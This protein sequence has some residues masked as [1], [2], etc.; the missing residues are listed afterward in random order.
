MKINR[1]TK[2]MARLG[3]RISGRP[4]NGYW[5]DVRRKKRKFKANLIWLFPAIASNNHNK[6]RGDMVPRWRT[7]N[8]QFY[9]EKRYKEISRDSMSQHYQSRTL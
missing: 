5:H 2:E 4:R 3:M 9:K 7:L 8:K 6:Y 1:R